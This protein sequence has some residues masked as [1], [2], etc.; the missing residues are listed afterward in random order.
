MEKI[1]HA[2]RR[3]ESCWSIYGYLMN[4]ANILLNSFQLWYVEHVKRNANET[5][6]RLAKTTI[7]Y[8]LV[9]I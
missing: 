6:Q 5:A 3:D 4:N 1:D 2:L 8:Y 7:S 9:Q